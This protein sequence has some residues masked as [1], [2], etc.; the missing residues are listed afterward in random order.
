MSGLRKETGLSRPEPHSADSPRRLY[1]FGEFTL[2]VESGFLRRGLAEV[3][4]RPKS[5]EVLTYLVEHHG[6]LV[7]KDALLVSI[8]PDTATTDNSLAQ[9]LTEIRRALDKDSQHSIRTV[10]RRGYVFTA[11]V[12]SLMTGFPG[13][14][15][16]TTSRPS[17]VP[18]PYRR[19]RR[20]SCSL[21]AGRFIITAACSR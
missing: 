11:P 5:L 19:R 8:W 20:P 17:P 15:P 21:R 1:Y 13:Q 2:D 12:T 6:R 9:C 3:N 18:C 14:S 4:L 16:G 10:A 7:S